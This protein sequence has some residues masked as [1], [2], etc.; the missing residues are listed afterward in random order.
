MLGFSTLLITTALAAGVASAGENAEL[1][2]G[3]THDINSPAY[4]YA[5]EYLRQLCL[6]NKLRCVLRSLPGRRSEAMLA[7]GKIDGEFGRVKAY[8]IRHPE[9]ARV[10]EP[11]N[12]SLTR[13]FTRQPHDISNWQSLTSFAHT[14]SYKRGVFLYQQRLESMRPAV[15]LHDVQSEAACLQVVLARHS[16]ACVF[17]DGGV[18]GD[19][20]HLLKQG[21]SSASIEDLPLYIY[22]DKRHAALAAPLNET[23]K[24]M[25]ARGIPAQLRRSYYELK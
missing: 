6:E 15:Q 17:D 2:F 3:T 12:V 19:A 11:F 22:L 21:Y 10:E 20:Q 16:D 5:H 23:A 14:V 25:L 4:R 18:S 1:V 7:I 13:I 9:Y 8:G 24:R